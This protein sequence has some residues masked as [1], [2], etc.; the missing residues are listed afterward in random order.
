MHPGVTVRVSPATGPEAP[1]GPAPRAVS[2]TAQ[3]GDGLARAIWLSGA[4][5]PRPLCMGLGRCGR[6][7][8]R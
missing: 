7:R 5:P 8:V 3:P 6:C 4:V 1:G 2:F